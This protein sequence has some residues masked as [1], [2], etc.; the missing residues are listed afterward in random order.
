VALVVEFLAPVT[1]LVDALEVL[2]AELEATEAEDA[3]ED[4]EADAEEE[5]D[6]DTDADADAL[7]ETVADPVAVA[8][9]MP[10]S[11]L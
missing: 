9:L 11:G 1:E 3:D 6:A 8:P 7:D 4:T 2:L 10:K 5:T